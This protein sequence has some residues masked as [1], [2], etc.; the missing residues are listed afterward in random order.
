MEFED[1]V[2]ADFCLRKM[3]P[4]II[5]EVNSVCSETDLMKFYGIHSKESLLKEKNKIELGLR[6]YNKSFLYFNIFNK[7]GD[8]LLGWC[9][10]HT[11]YLEHNR[12]EIGYQWFLED[13][14]NKGH[15]SKI[16]K[17]VINYGFNEMN[18]NRIE[19]MTASYNKA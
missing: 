6:T 19:A 17:W 7:A 18:L 4:E 3:T 13:A 8:Q 1:H 11:W 15:M 12:A 5:K 16:L 2:I 14:K 9:G 10:Y